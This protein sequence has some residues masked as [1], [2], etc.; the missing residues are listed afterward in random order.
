[1]P[2]VSRYL[3]T[4][5]DER[6]WKFDRP[7]I[8][9]GEWCRLYDRKHIWQGMDAIVAQPYGL[10]QKQK[11]A[12]HAEARSLEEKLFPILCDALNQYHGTQ[13]GARFWRIVLG[14]WL[15]RYVDV[16][17]N[18]VKTLEQC[19]KLYQVS[20]TMA[21]TD[22][23]YSL[24]T[25]NSY[26]SVYAFNDDRWNNAL[27]LRILN[28]LGVTSC[29]VD[30]IAEDKV[31]GFRW[32][33][34]AVNVSLK[35]R[36]LMWGFHNV[37]E[38]V[39]FL[40]GE[41][42]AF[43][44][45]SYLPKKE[46]IKLHL[47]LG[48]VPQLWATTQRETTIKSD[49]TLRQSLFEQTAV[50]TRDNLF[51]V[52]CSL[53]FEFMPVCYLEGFAEL[54]EKVQQLPWPQ[55]P[56]LIFTSNNFDTDEVFKLSTAT[57]VESG[58]TYIAGQHGNNYGTSRYI[59]PSVE[60][61]TSDKYLTWG[62]TD[63]LPQHTPAFLFKIAG[64]N[65]EPLATNGGLLLIEV[66]ESH[67]ITTWDGTYE[68]AGYFKDQQLFVDDL[69]Q[70][71]RKNLT[72]RL[73][74]GHRDT[75]WGE[76]RRWKEFDPDIKID[77]SE[78]AISKLISQSRLIVHSYDSTGILETLAQNIPTLA[79]WQNDFEHLRDSAKPYYQHL[80]DVG[81]FHL[82]PES[83]AA[84]VNEIWDDVGG[85]W[86]QSEVQEARKQFCDRYAKVDKDPIPQLKN[87]LL[88]SLNLDAKQKRID[89]KNVHTL[90]ST[91][92]TYFRFLSSYYQ[93]MEMKFRQHTNDY[94]HRLVL[95]AALPKSGSSWMESLIFAIP[96]YRKLRRYDPKDQLRLHIL[97]AV[98]LENL[99]TH[100]NF[101]IKTHIEAQPEGVAALRHNK[102]PTII[103]VRDLRDQCVSHFHHV[104]EDPKHKYHD[105]YKRMEPEEAF[106]Q[107]LSNNLIGYATWIR[108]WQAV[109]R[110][111]DGFFLFV[112]YENLQRDVKS[113]FSRVLEYIDVGLDDQS[114]NMLIEQVKIQSNAEKDFAKRLK[115]RNTL[116]AG[117][118]GDWKSYF[119]S[120]DV[121]YFKAHANDVLVSLGYEKDDEWFANNNE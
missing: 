6:T 10:G 69:A 108:N 50:K 109:V 84:K 23:H 42:D 59:Y 121:E 107:F 31:D 105:L 46:E 119:S 104:L 115:K 5:A 78:I 7:V 20:G 77:R 11:D 34:T 95:I 43:I 65:V 19:L 24:A 51:E 117:R 62:W 26:E 83:A 75:R 44:I 3:I 102:V 41:N 63:G 120:R 101:V 17:L 106:S 90:K 54:T 118:I 29:P 60:E 16:I 48:Q 22:E 55:N 113:E 27:Y 58:V 64:R 70:S 35:R 112:R 97:D 12:D 85:W 96:Q 25:T 37:R 13:H 116:R 89:E 52:M 53:L 15:R 103:M 38:L 40:A 110:E 87:I 99:P 36:L 81:I 56:K 9:L 2:D 88:S 45:N 80:V 21:Y 94:P 18:R 32:H 33:A 8:F 66:Y 74:S 14:H 111:D 47:A 71:P 57:K 73:H 72:L 39:G 79:F 82:T 4:S 28:L 68:F 114:V 86:A 98:L 67:R 92:D 49:R 61:A 91:F 100:G 1:M 30:I 93:R 76:E